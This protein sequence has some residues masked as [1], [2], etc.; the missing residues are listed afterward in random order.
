MRTYVEYPHE[1][2]LL[3]VA[4]LETVVLLGERAGEGDDLELGLFAGVSVSEDVAVVGVLDELPGGGE[5][6]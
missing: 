4:I 6:L 5:G 1:I 3:V 2:L